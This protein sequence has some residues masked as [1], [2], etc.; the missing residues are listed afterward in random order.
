MVSE[1]APQKS[2]FISNLSQQSLV[3][4]DPKQHI[5]TTQYLIKI[6]EKASTIPER[7]SARF[8]PNESPEMSI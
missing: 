2:E 8:V 4:I 3:H 5:F 6:V 7:L 1:I